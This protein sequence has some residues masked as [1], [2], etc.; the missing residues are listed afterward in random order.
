LMC[1]MA[2]MHVCG[3]NDWAQPWALP[4]VHGGLKYLQVLEHGEMVLGF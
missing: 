4:G 2:Q 1:Q 3:G